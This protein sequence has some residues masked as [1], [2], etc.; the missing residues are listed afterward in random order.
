MLETT[1]Y[2]PFW[3]ATAGKWVDAADLVEGKS[4][5]VGPDGEIQY[6]IDVHAFD[7]SKVMRDLTVAE[8]H[9]Y[10]VIAQQRTSPRA[11]LRLRR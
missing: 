9:T 8:I 5:L 4:T 11:Q 7:G 10:Y 2:H 1:A 6:V 3:D